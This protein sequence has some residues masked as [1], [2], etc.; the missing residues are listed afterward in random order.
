MV[1]NL[2]SYGRCNYIP[3]APPLTCRD[4]TAAGR[5]LSAKILE[6]FSVYMS[7]VSFI[8]VCGV[9]SFFSNVPVEALSISHTLYKIKLQLG[10]SFPDPR[11]LLALARSSG[12]PHA[13]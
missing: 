13:W 5:E 1:L 7:V 8:G 10:L 3:L 9:V 11:H 12:L 2:I 6:R 4:L